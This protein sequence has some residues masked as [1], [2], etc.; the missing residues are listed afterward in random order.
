MSRLPHIDWKKYT[1]FQQRVLKAICSI[2]KGRVMTYGQVAA[3]IGN[4]RAARAVG[5]ALKANQDAPT[6][7]CHRVVGS[8]NLGGY[9]GRGG[10]RSKIKLLKSEGCNFK[11]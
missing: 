1:P 9:S 5:A 4:P 2:P 10:V 8:G 7:P 3:K 6:V 11:D